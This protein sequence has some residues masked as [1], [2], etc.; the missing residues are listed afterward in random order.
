MPLSSPQVSLR[1]PERKKTGQGASGGP[2]PGL[3]RP[4][5]VA[6]SPAPSRFF[7]RLAGR[8]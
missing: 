7:A 2:A 1:R 8:P 4:A 3:S 6:V 5:R